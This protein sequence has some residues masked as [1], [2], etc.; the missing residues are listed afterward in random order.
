MTST[1]MGDPPVFVQSTTM[2]QHRLRT[3]NAAGGENLL[4]GDIGFGT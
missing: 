4:D 2:P 3:A 1:R